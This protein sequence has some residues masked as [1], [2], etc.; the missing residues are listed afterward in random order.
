MRCSQ[1]R[2]RV[3]GRRLAHTISRLEFESP[4]RE[5]N[6]ATHVFPGHTRDYI[7]DPTQ[8]DRKYLFGTIHETLHIITY[9]SVCVKR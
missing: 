1:D 4:A 6:T 7:F 5:F 2:A 9:V 3:A 8:N